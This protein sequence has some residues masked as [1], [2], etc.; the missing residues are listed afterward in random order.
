MADYD[1]LKHG[2]VSFPLVESL[3][4][5]FLRD[6]D[7]T[8]YYALEFFE[9][10]LNKHLLPRL[11]MESRKSDGAVISTC[12]ANKVWWDPEPTLDAS[13]FKFPLLAVFRESDVIAEQTVKWEKSVDTINVVWVMPPLLGARMQ[14]L[15]PALHAARDI[16]TRTASRGFDPE[17]EGGANVWALAGAQQAGFTSFRYGAFQKIANTAAVFPTLMATLV[18]HEREMPTDD[19]FER[20]LSVE[21]EVG[22][23]EPDAEGDPVTD[24]IKVTQTL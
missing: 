15:Y 7:P 20:L 19:D 4:N 14:Q 11:V 12:V 5:S 10:V 24:D 18:V 3:D 1:T 13:Q 2:G 9:C 16:L 17:F 23:N 22:T 21:I 8:V 6:A